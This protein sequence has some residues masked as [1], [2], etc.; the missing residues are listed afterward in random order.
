LYGGKFLT[1]NCFLNNSEL[2]ND[3]KLS[4]IV[5]LL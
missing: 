1:N 4:D 5:F 2:P 3:K